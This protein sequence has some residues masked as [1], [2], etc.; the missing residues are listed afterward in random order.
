MLGVRRNIGLKFT[1]KILL[2]VYF[3]TV[4]SDNTTVGRSITSTCGFRKSYRKKDMKEAGS[5]KAIEV[6]TSFAEKQ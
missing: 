1:T 3:Q 4:Q 5:K 6:M 2:E